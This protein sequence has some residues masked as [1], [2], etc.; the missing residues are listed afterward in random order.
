MLECGLREVGAQR[1]VGLRRETG[2][3]AGKAGVIAWMPASRT[4][5][6]SPRQMVSSIA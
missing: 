1:P 5:Q 3:V 6:S 4:R 2:D